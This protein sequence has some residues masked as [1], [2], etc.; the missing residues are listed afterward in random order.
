MH[1]VPALLLAALFVTCTGHAAA[2]SLVDIEI[3]PRNGSHALQTHSRDGQAY[4]VGTPG[5]R[6]AV[7]LTNRSSRRVLAV[8]SVDGIN[9]VSGETAAPSQAGY[10]LAPFATEEVSGWRKSMREVAQFYFASLADSYAARTD[11]PHNVGVIGVAAFRERETQLPMPYLEQR[12]PQRAPG[13][14]GKAQS[15]APASGVATDA[16]SRAEAERIGTGHGPREYAPVE[17][18]DFVRARSSPDEIVTVN[19]DTYANLLAR[20]IIAHAPCC[21][22]PQP[23]P[24]FF[25]PDPIR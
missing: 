18:T 17:Y 8:L 10:V 21:G 13:S 11:R 3:V 5:E 12:D 19:Y 9:A 15:P 1:I 6:Y 22:Q 23:F 16:P 24:G 2:R 7:R 20:G 25:V 4:V 14:S